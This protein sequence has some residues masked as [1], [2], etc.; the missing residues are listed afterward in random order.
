MPDHDLMIGEQVAGI[1]VVFVAGAIVTNNTII[2]PVAGIA[3][4]SSSYAAPY[5]EPTAIFVDCI[6]GSAVVKN[7]VINNANPRIVSQVSSTS[8]Q[9]FLCFVVRT[10]TS[11]SYFCMIASSA[12]I[13]GFT[14]NRLGQLKS[15][16]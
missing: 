13:D 9:I 1:G 5:A 8:E 2:N 15:L 3:D 4:Q 7:N 6:S 16:Q 11:V 10:P 12:C 14:L